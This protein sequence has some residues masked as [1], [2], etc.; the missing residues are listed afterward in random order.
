MLWLLI[1]QL[2]MKKISNKA[3]KGKRKS[4]A[5]IVV[6][7]QQVAP[8]VKAHVELQPS[9]EYVN[10]LAKYIIDLKEQLKKLKIQNGTAN[11]KVDVLEAKLKVTTGK[12][13]EF[14]CQLV[15]KKE[16]M[17]Y[18]YERLLCDNL[19]LTK[20]KETI[21]SFKVGMENT[22]SGLLGKEKINLR[23]IR[24]LEVSRYFLQNQ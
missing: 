23:K 12:A 1:F 7:T 8:I 2:I 18:G 14:G 6:T 13:E 15:F 21:S 16:K 24:D 9:F 3:T 4:T 5:K 22:I 11:I 20:E 19:A 17:D 10:G